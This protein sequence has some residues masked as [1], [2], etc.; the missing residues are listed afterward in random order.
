MKYKKFPQAQGALKIM[1]MNAVGRGEPAEMPFHVTD[2]P[3]GFC[4]VQVELTTA[5]LRAIKNKGGE[6]F[7]IYGPG[8]ASPPIM[9]ITTVDPFSFNTKKLN[10]KDKK[11]DS[12]SDD[13]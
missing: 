5:E 9:Q 7:I 8:S 10:G 12:P 2:N 3:A 6:F 11:E 13:E 4:V 1:T